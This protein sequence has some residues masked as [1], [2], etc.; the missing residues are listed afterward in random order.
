MF[1]DAYAPPSVQK[2]ESNYLDFGSN[3][4]KSAKLLF[5]KILEMVLV[6]EKSKKQTSDLS[7]SVYL[8][9]YLKLTFFSFY[10]INVIYICIV[11]LVS[12]VK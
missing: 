2:S 12:K 3:R 7:V 9:I 10:L 6:D 8:F 1:C 5:Y 4:L 11:N